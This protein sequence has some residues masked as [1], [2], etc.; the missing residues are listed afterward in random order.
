[1]KQYEL[2]NT[3]KKL[4]NEG[5]IDYKFEDD[6]GISI[7]LKLDKGSQVLLRNWVD[8]DTIHFEGNYSLGF[9]FLGCAPEDENKANYIYWKGS[10]DYFIEDPDFFWSDGEYNK[11]RYGNKI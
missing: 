10:H 1:M 2:S 4:L 6:N 5:E 3:A 9:P 11:K 7:I 8:P